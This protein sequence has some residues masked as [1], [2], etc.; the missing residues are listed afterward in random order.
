ML[1]CLQSCT[2]F[3][4][5]I[6]A[7]LPLLLFSPLNLLR[8]IP[9]QPPHLYFLLPLISLPSPISLLLLSLTLSSIYLF[10]ICPLPHFHS[11]ISSI[12]LSN[13]FSISLFLL[14]PLL[15]PL[16]LFLSLFLLSLSLPLFNSFYL[17]REELYLMWALGVPGVQ[18]FYHLRVSQSHPIL[19]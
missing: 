12:K 2:T 11:F 16:H 3:S 9:S 8:P 10:S 5:F 14:S 18:P 1:F 6:S 13:L 7:L 17:C 4:P 19:T 15:S